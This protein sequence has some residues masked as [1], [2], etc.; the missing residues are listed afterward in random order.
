MDD[1]ATQRVRSFNRTVTQRIGALQRR[2]P[3]AAARPLGASRVLW[4]I[5]ER[6]RRRARACARGLDLDSGYL[7]RLLRSLEDDGLVVVGARRGGRRVR[8]VAAHRR[9]AAVERAVLDRR[10]DE[11]AALAAGAARATPQRDRLVEAMGDRRAA[12]HRRP[13]RRRRRATPTSRRGAVLHRART[14]PSSTRASTTRVR[15]RPKHLGRRRRAH[16]ACR[17]CSSSPGC[18]GEPVGCGALKLHG[19]RPRRDQAHVGRPERPAGLGVGRRILH[20][21]EQQRRPARRV[22]IVRLET[23]RAPAR[24]E[25]PVPVGRLRGGR[26]RSTTSPTPTTGSRSSCRSGRFAALR[27]RRWRKAGIEGRGS[28]PGRCSRGRR[29]TSRSDRNRK[30][31][32]RYASRGRKTSI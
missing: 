32:R 9:P 14:S 1:V 13:G 25:R 4:E 16:R 10:S 31:D 18:A 5:G 15:S 12:A 2:V 11:L 3:G 22:D 24:G 28:E 21:L 29:K 27:R 26:R 20:E 8:T 30:P 23:N 6:R 7:S 17:R 19:T